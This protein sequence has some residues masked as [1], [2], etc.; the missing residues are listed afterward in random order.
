MG[1]GCIALPCHHCGPLLSRAPPKQQP[2]FVGARGSLLSR[3]PYIIDRSRLYG[4]RA[5]VIP[6]PDG[7]SR[8]DGY[9]TRSARRRANNNSADDG[10]ERASERAKVL[11]RVSVDGAAS[12][13]TIPV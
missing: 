2:S 9:R 7:R 10:D 12:D 13:A 6:V 1:T 8:G 4:R 3:A 11:H 5:A